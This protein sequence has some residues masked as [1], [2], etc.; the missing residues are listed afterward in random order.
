MH[1]ILNRFKT[2]MKRKPVAGVLILMGAAAGMAILFRAAW[3]FTLPRFDVPYTYDGQKYIETN[4]PYTYNG[5]QYFFINEPYET[6]RSAVKKK[7][8]ARFYDAVIYTLEDDPDEFYLYPR[9]FLAHLPYGLMGRLDMMQRPSP[10]NVA[11]MEIRHPQD[12]EGDWK[13]LDE[14]TR[15]AIRESYNWEPLDDG[16]RDAILEAYVNT[17]LPE[18]SRRAALARREWQNRPG[19]EVYE[20]RLQFRHPDDLYYLLLAVQQDGAWYLVMEDGETLAAFDGSSLQKR[21][22]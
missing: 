17:P 22:E 5:R 1:A 18:E 20:L 7:A 10:E 19:C 13:T 14:D 16:T 15:N 4:E 21:S 6:R 12:W 3:L 11:C 9:V 8:V 2:I